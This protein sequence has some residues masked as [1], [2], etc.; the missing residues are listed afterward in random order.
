MGHWTH[1]SNTRKLQLLNS[2]LK[3]HNV[4]ASALNS[5]RPLSNV[6][7]IGKTM[8][9]IVFNQICNYLDT[10][11]FFYDYHSGFSQ[12]YSKE[13]AVVKVLIDV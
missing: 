6:Y 12:H 1:F 9:N 8:E 4:D 13:T 7:F 3:K 11:G 5:Y 2:L 10:N